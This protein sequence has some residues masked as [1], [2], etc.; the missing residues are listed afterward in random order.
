MT[1][2][3]AAFIDAMA[4]FILDE[5]ELIKQTFEE[6]LD[7]R[8]VSDFIRY[9]TAL[10]NI[11]ETNEALATTTRTHLRSGWKPKVKN[12]AKRQFF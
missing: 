4:E 9:F 5:P 7:Y 10:L 1:V 8:N 6:P 12:S 2:V 11:F 3:N